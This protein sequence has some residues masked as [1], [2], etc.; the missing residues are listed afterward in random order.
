[1]QNSID[2]SALG[3]ASFRN[4][5]DNTAQYLENISKA[6]NRGLT[7][8]QG[9]ADSQADDRS[10]QANDYINSLTTADALAGA[11]LSST[12]LKARFGGRLNA[13]VFT[14]ASGQNKENQDLFLSNQ[15]FSDKKKS[16]DDRS[17][18]QDLGALLVKGQQ[19]NNFSEYE[20]ALSKDGF[21]FGL[22][23]RSSRLSQGLAT[24]RQT[25][26]YF[27]QQAKEA[28]RVAG[29][30][31]IGSA[32]DFS[33]N[34]RNETVDE[35]GNM[36]TEFNDFLQASG[37]SKDA[38]GNYNITQADT[39]TFKASQN[40][41][42]TF[43][44]GQAEA[45]EQYGDFD[46]N[47]KFTKLGIHPNTKQIA[48]G[49]IEEGNRLRKIKFDE[50]QVKN[51]SAIQANPYITLNQ[52]GKV[53]A[54]EYTTPEGLFNLK[55]IGERRKTFNDR[56]AAF[57]KGVASRQEDRRI[58]EKELGI[59]GIYK[60]GLENLRA[61]SGYKASESTRRAQLEQTYTSQFDAQSRNSGFGDRKLALAN[62]RAST[63]ASS[64][65]ATAQAA[66]DK[67][68]PGKPEYETVEE[69]SDLIS[70]VMDEIN[71]DNEGS[72]VLGFL[73][74]DGVAGKELRALISSEEV[75]YI[76]LAGAERKPVPASVMKAAIKLATLDDGFWQ[77]KGVRKDKLKAR[78]Q[79][80][81]N[82][83]SKAFNTADLGLNQAKA[84]TKKIQEQIL[85]HGQKGQTLPQFG[86]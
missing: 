10:Q 67:F 22:N 68:T 83:R 12:A 61:S 14:N 64:Q 52:D 33:E 1:M 65:L 69:Q 76:K 53:E 45:L 60:R 42:N 35:F 77:D 24:R 62:Q 17:I 9:I 11:D 6:L 50:D 7:R 41:V 26:T 30:T 59:N 15:A 3:R 54:T 56:K 43:S 31:A 16:I 66:F 47:A 51:R 34:D 78:I 29:E 75:R 81:M 70:E 23:D 80:L 28:T 63:E 46:P 37:A 86:K 72:N 48:I 55:E 5:K 74:N 38:D 44:T 57:D 40:A 49:Y 21:A 79:E 82:A 85:N 20:A 4:G 71:I 25:E 36:N 13:N 27:K 19:T 8:V 58:L 32:I 39:D 18:V 84:N 73:G 2:V